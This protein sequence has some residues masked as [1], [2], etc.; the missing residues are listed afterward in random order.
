MLRNIE[1]LLIWNGDSESS[2]GKDLVN[3]D[4]QGEFAFVVT[5]ITQDKHAG[6]VCTGRMFS[7]T[8]KKGM[9]VMTSNGKTRKNSAS[10]YFKRTSKSSN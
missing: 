3:C 9:D 7:G 6:E 10:F 2:E 8:V 4:P 1:F 5:K